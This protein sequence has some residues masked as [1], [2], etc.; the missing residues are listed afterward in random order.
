MFPYSLSFEEFAA[1]RPWKFN[2]VA[3]VAALNRLVAGEVVEALQRATGERRKLMVICPV[4]PLDYSYWAERMNQEQTDGSR[5]ITVNMDEY[6]GPE[7]GFIEQSHPLCF[8]R[9]MWN[10]FFDRL[11]GRA[12]VP[13]HNIISLRLAHRS[14]RPS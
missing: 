1:L 6:L 9:F 8:R 14:Q 2:K 13:K 7:G 12:R 5:L 11:Q 3:D 4:G 10:N